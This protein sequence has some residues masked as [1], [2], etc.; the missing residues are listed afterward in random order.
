MT[1]VRSLLSIVAAFASI[2]ITACS[3]WPPH[4]QDIRENLFENREVFEE[5]E[6]ILDSNGYGLI[7]R[8]GTNSVRVGYEANGEIQ[9]DFIDDDKGWGELLSK[10][11]VMDIS[12][13]EDVYFFTISGSNDDDVYTSFQY[14]HHPNAD[15]ELKICMPDHRE[16]PCGECIAKLDDEWWAF[17]KWFPNNFSDDDLDALIEGKI[18]QEEYDQRSDE[19]IDSCWRDGLSKMGYELSEVG[20]S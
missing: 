1:Q 14:I 8:M 6:D 5:L 13:N 16:I 12:R 2:G 7:R 11:K 4:E 3:E 18:S 9:Y 10:A 17:Y 20:E 15:L 19:A